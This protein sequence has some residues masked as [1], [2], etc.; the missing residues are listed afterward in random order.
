[1]RLLKSPVLS[2]LPAFLMMFYAHSQEIYEKKGIAIHGYDIV[3]YFKDRPERGKKEFATTYKGIVFLFSSLAHKEAFINKPSR[4][5]PQYGGFCAYAMALKGKKVKIDPK[6]Y[7]I[8]N[9]KLYLF[10]HSGKT[11]TLQ[12]WNK[13]GAEI[14]I[15]KANDNWKILIHS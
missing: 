3:S 6:T 11:N 15:P 8:R 5:L 2:F 1:M 4:F 10:Y 7:E 14:L 9:G 13:E 12:L